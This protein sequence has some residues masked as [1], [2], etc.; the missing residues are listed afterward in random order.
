MVGEEPS[1]PTWNDGT[2]STREER[3]KI[4]RERKALFPI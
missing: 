1:N 4:R 2:N 3:K